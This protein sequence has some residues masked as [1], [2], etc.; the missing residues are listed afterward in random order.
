MNRPVIDCKDCT[1]ADTCRYHAM[2]DVTGCT[3]GVKNS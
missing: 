3:S 1:R 2:T